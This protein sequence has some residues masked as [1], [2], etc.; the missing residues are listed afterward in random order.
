MTTPERGMLIVNGEPYFDL[1]VG[2]AHDLLDAMS[3]ASGKEVMGAF[4]RATPTMEERL[5]RIAKEALERMTQP[6]QASAG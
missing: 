1:T 4:Y 2:E 3:I 6:R 5:K